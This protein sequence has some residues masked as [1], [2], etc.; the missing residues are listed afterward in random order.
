MPR[1]CLICSDHRKLARAGELIAAGNSDQAV[2]NALNAMTPDMPAMSL[3]AVSR[4]RRAHILAP[5]KA[6]AEAAGKGRQVAEQRAQVLAAFVSASSV[7]PR[8]R[9]MTTSAQRLSQH[10][11]VEELQHLGCTF[12]ITL[13]HQIDRRPAR[14]RR[15]SVPL[16][17]PCRRQFGGPSAA[18][19]SGT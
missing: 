8:A 11:T 9:Y 14:E 4:H 5:A 6:L 16:K 3:M 19:I 18:S 1:P 7:L 17:Q 15:D 12:A 10:R 2:A 13:S